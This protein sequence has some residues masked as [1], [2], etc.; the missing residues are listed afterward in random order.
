MLAC[1]CT[2]RWISK[3]A[4]PLRSVTKWQCRWSTHD[5]LN[6]KLE[7]KQTGNN[8]NTDTNNINMHVWI[9][10]VFVHLSFQLQQSR[11]SGQIWSSKTRPIRDFRAS[12]TCRTVVG[13]EAAKSGGCW[14]TRSCFS[15]PKGSC[16][17]SL[18]NLRSGSMH[19]DKLILLFCLCL[20]VSWATQ[21]QEISQIFSA[22][23]GVKW[24]PLDVNHLRPAQGKSL[25]GR[26]WTL[27]SEKFCLG[28]AYR[29]PLLF[30]S[31]Y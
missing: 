24:L 7:K 3:Q 6:L 30:W 1:A 16:G 13:S 23:R 26:H 22:C 31:I 21:P 5:S 8:N 27:G 11:L 2:P 20:G 18:R 17:T 9:S 12:C 28:I 4:E 19:F 14:I 10:P 15:S 29:L 25:S